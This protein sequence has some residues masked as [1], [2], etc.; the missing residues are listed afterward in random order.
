MMLSSLSKLH[1]GNFRSKKKN[2]KY[3][4]CEW[5][6]GESGNLTDIK[7]WGGCWEIPPLQNHEHHMFKLDSL[8]FLGS[9]TKRPSSPLLPSMPVKENSVCYIFVQ[10]WHKWGW[11]SASSW[12]QVVDNTGLWTGRCE[13][14]F[15]GLLEAC[16]LLELLGKAVSMQKVKSPLL[17]GQHGRIQAIQ[18]AL[19]CSKNHSRLQVLSEPKS[20][21]SVGAAAPEQFGLWRLVAASAAVT[22]RWWGVRSWGKWGGR[23]LWKRGW[24]HII[25][26][27]CSERTGEKMDLFEFQNWM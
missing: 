1:T 19:E 10:A 2:K 25:L 15:W 4:W 26:E 7:E 20:R 21:F 11:R 17:V 18:E 8:G 5:K 27:M 14:W 23:W 3:H 24:S 9:K 12:C 6:Q 13:G 22:M 16:G